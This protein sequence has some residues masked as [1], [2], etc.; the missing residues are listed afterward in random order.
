MAPHQILVIRGLADSSPWIAAT[1]DVEKIPLSFGFSPDGTRAAVGNQ[2]NGA[3]KASVTLLRGLPA[4][5]VI[6]RTLGLKARAKVLSAVESV[7]FTRRGDSLVA[8]IGLHDEAAS[9]GFFLANV[10]LQVVHDPFGEPEVS[11]PLRIPAGSWI[12]PTPPF[13]GLRTGRALGDSALLCDGDTLVTPVP[14]ALD[15]GQPDARIVIVRGVRTG[16]LS[17]QRTLTPLDGVGIAPF[18][19]TLA[20]DCSAI[21]TNTFSSTVT[22]I[23][24]LLDPDPNAIRLLSW[25]TSYPFPAEPAVV[26]N[27][28]ALFVHHPRPPISN[29]PPAAVS[30]YRVRDGRIL[31]RRVVEGPV[32]AW[33]QV[34]DQTL[35]TWPAGLVDYLEGVLVPVSPEAGPDTDQNRRKGRGRSGSPAGRRAARDEVIPAAN[36]SACQRRNYR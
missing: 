1:L 22:R 21:V 4:A 36:P 24:G 8:Q 34:K 29:V 17:I 26:A 6:D 3:G 13:E 14:G 31:K 33:L 2:L 25:N 35:A 23:T 32:R 11:S 9:P 30:G 27:G 5:P 12:P 19:V 7:E 10:V 16:E 28:S 18:Q 20:N 15:I